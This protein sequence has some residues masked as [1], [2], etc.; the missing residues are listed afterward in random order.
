MIELMITHGD[1]A[2]MHAC[3][4]ATRSRAKAGIAMGIAAGSIAIDAEDPRTRGAAAAAI[5]SL[6]LARAA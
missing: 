5:A 2:L 1:R 6:M 4:S 3:M